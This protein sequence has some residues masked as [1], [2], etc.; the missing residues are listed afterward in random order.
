MFK[1]FIKRPILSGVISV[2][3]IC[4]G[5]LAISTLPITQFPDIV[6]PSV[7]V[8]ARYTGASADVM[9]KT[10][11]TPLERA[12]NGVPGMTY[13]TTVC[14]ND[15]MS[16]TTIY[17]KVGTDPD[18]AAVNVQNRVT[19]VLDELPEEVIRAGVI[20][21]KEVNS[22][23]MYLNILSS[24]TTH[25]ENFVYNFTDINILRELKRIDGVGFV[26]IMGSRDYAM[27]VWLN[28][29]R[30]AVY[31]MSPQDVTEAIRS[32][33]IEAAP[34]KTGISSDKLPQQLQY[35]LQYTGKFSTPE[36]YGEIVLKAL[37]DGSLLKL[38]DVAEI[39]FDSEDYNMISMTDGKPS[40]AIMIKQRPGSNAKEVIENI[41]AKMEEIKESSFLPGMD[42]NISYDVS[43]FLDASISSVLKT[44]L[45][46]FILVFIVVYIFLQNFRSTLIPAIAVPVSLIGT[47]F[48]MDMLGFSI[49][50][51]TLF[52]LV[53]AIGIVVDN[54]IVVVEAVH[55][56]MEREK[57]SPYKASVE[58]MKEIGGAIVAITLVMS[59]VFVPVGFMSGTVGIFY[60]QFSLTLAVAIVISGINALTLSPALCALLLKHDRGK[61]KRP[62]LL[63]RFFIV[64]NRGYERFERRYN[65]GLKKYL[66]RKFFTYATLIL[67]FLAT[68]GMSSILPTGFIPNEDQGMIYVNVNT[69]PGATLERSEKAL[70]QI[71][72]ALLPMDEIETISTLAGYS[73]M[74]ETED[75]SYGMGMIN[76]KPWNERDKTAA[77]LLDV[78][79]ERTAH[80]KD[81]EIQY[82]L[83]PTV[84]GFG[85]ASGFEL[86]L[87]D[88]TAASFQETARVANMLVDS[89][90]RDP[91]L[92]GVT[93]G[94][95][96]NFPQYLLK[97][98]LA[99]AAKLGVNVNEALESL[100]SYVGSFY[101]SNFIR[102]GQMYKVMLQ[103]SPEYR[104]EPKDIYSLYAKNRNGEMVP[105]SNF[106][107]MERIF[108]PN[109][110]TRYNMFT[111][112]L[113][114]GDAALGV[115]TGE[116]IAAVEEVAAKIL[117]RGY[118]LEW[119]G[120]S[121]EE[122][123]S[124]GQTILIFG[125][126][127]L[128]VYLL[129]AAQ[130]ESLLLPF[131]VILSL[132]AGVFGAYFVL[133]L[134]GI[135]NNIYAQVALVM[136]I[137]LLGKNAILIIEMAN[138]FRKQGMSILEAAMKGAGSR[139]RPILMTS[140][141]FICGLIPLMMASGAGA[142]GNRSIGTAAAGGMLIGTMVGIF[143]V[144]GLYVVFESLATR[145]K[146]NRPAI[147]MEDYEA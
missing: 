1:L 34:G 122:K 56:K 72:A 77:E 100:Q 117:P 141:A 49:N 52:A 62:N 92:Q 131:P 126:C 4:L 38:K 7:T 44:L 45:E 119:S 128:F 71:Q 129:L 36:E 68:W 15:G 123:E 55:V 143:L 47:F 112:S 33:N 8:T 54:A 53:L 42:Y 43:R 21:E 144:P 28:P 98:D 105:Y 27:R 18:V 145:L 127:L 83:P 91:R 136:L 22:M 132:P 137:G 76:L 87:Q 84:P 97:V 26:E 94:F 66:G 69:P 50:M 96:P 142:L 14:T 63:R 5:A 39:D 108:G 111:S 17:F 134:A 31:N 118:A 74:T 70:N 6:P 10:V 113:I 37:P 125:I 24:D 64:F 41:K 75:A 67:F 124:G 12:I 23:L 147:D 93:S 89:L 65:I 46:A 19:T 51:L 25:T 114:T 90:N 32:Q 107:T 135:D 110:I 48:F 133:Q 2:L 40:A 115:S 60:Q 95:Q 85:N 101:S 58:A 13:M 3:F 73:L 82:F 11:A 146:R 109:Q 78:Y 30:L 9:S 140:F 120:V 130:Y 102:F 20:T 116:A 29:N 103:A 99:Q 61:S 138:Q 104:M 80:I 81:A 59:A 106:L 35:T 88:R 16:L 79:A 121:R 139:L 86:R 57:L